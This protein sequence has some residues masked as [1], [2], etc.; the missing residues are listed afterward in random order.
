MFEGL[1]ERLEKAS[2]HLQTGRRKGGGG[3]GDLAV[4]VISSMVNSTGETFVV[5]VPNHGAIS[6]LPYDAIVEVAATVD[7]LGPH[8]FA[9][10]DLPR[11][12]LGMQ[13]ALVLSQELAVDAALSGSRADLL[14]A[15]LAHPLI[16]SMSAA[17]QAMDELL[18]LQ[19]DWL[20]QFADGQRSRP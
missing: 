1:E 6:N 10:G 11:S 2:R 4:R 16:H 7:E 15:I 14:K 18:A 3:H 8:P 5:N 13:Y 19:A 12:L 9:T 20:P 17:E